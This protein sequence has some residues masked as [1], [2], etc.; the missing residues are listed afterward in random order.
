L[1]AIALSSI[2]GLWDTGSRIAGNTRP[3]LLVG[4]YRPPSPR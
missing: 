2:V 4:K 3:G 1:S